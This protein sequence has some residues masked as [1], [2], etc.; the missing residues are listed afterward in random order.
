MLEDQNFVGCS[1]P[2]MLD[3][4]FDCHDEIRRIKKELVDISKPP[5][6]TTKATICPKCGGEV[7]INK[8]SGN[9][10]CIECDYKIAGKQ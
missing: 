10:F 7:L 8:P 1:S 9:G 6:N 2:L 5:T 4:I 3:H